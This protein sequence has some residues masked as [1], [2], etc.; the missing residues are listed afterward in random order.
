MVF[1]AAAIAGY[2][3]RRI[4]EPKAAFGMSERSIRESAK[5]VGYAA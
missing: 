3:Y 1:V 4:D 2:P 5:R